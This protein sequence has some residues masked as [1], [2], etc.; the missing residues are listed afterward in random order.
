MAV[1]PL[2]ASNGVSDLKR[3]LAYARGHGHSGLQ[4]ALGTEPF[5]PVLK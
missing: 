4:L 5:N 2:P 1:A 3:E